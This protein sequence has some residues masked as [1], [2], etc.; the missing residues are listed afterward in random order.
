MLDLSYRKAIVGLTSA[1]LVLGAADVA[2]AQGWLAD[3]KN[4]EGPGIRVGN[5]ELH[6]GVGIEAGYDSNIF[7]EKEDPDGSAILRTTAHLLLSTIGKERREEGEA[8]EDR[9]QSQ[10]MLDFRG[11]LNFSHYHYFHDAVPDNVSGD[12][13]LDAT[14]NPNGPFTFRIYDVFSRSVRPFSNRPG[15]RDVVFGRNRNVAGVNLSLA[16]RSR[17]LRGNVG[18]AIDYDFFD[19]DDFRY[20]NSLTHRVQAGA[21]WKFLPNTALLYELDLRFQGYNKFSAAD[22][23]TLL[24]DTIRLNNRVGLNGAITNT[25]SVAALVGYSAGFYDDSRLEDFD[26]ANA[27]V[28][29][30]WTPRDTVRTSLGYVRDFNP[31]FVGNTFQRDQVYAKANLMLLGSLLVVPQASVAFAQTDLAVTPDGDPLGNQ[32]NRESIRL[33]LSLFSEYRFT[34]WLAV[35][36]T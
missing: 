5:L 8:T 34:N 11:G 12:L 1:L 4:A 19:D 14:I 27:R 36:A 3:R 24:S 21:N 25:F 7:L 2:Q 17:T 22:S 16:S 15:V 23:P 32:L 13:F 33:R 26:S 35:N 18:Y 30:R 6:P 29:A 10:R 20:A 31:S 9:Q 28:E